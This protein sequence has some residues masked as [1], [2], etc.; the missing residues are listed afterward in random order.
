[1]AAAAPAPPQPAP[2]RGDRARGAPGRQYRPPRPAGPPRRR[3]SGSTTKVPSVFDTRALP[4]AV[5]GRGA[6]LPRELQWAP[7]PARVQ[8]AGAL[9]ERPPQRDRVP[10]RAPDRAQRRSLYAVHARGARP[11]A[12]ANQRARGDRR[13]PQGPGA[14]P[15][16]GGT[17]AGSS[18]RCELVPAGRAHIEDLG[19]DVAGALPRTGARLPGRA[20]ARRR[21]SQRSGARAHLAVARGAAALAERASHTQ[22]A[23][24]SRASAS[25]RRR[26]AALD[27]RCRRPQL[28]SPDSPAALHRAASR[29]ATAARCSRS[30]GGGSGCARWRSSTGH[31][32]L[33]NRRIQLRGRLD[34]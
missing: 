25:K 15:R 14:C 5:S 20:A 32:Y 3:A 29:C 10:E 23:S 11:A 13:Q 26:V 19:H 12:W 1:M 34:P 6:A 17:G 21:C 33:N 30:T 8:L 27:A 16:A 24:A 18:G 28:W 22:H 4:C 2:P 31:L 9:R 7:H